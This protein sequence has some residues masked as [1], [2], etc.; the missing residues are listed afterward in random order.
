MSDPADPTHDPARAPTPTNRL[1]SETSLYLRQHMHDPV[2]WHPWG[3]EAR[4]RA[5]T[6]DKPLLVSIGYSACH[7]CH[8]ME[9]ESFEDPVTAALMNECFV[10]IKVD[11]EERPDVDQLYMDAV[12]RMQGHGGW[13]LT[14]F[15]RA[16][17]TPFYGGTYYPPEPRH[18]LPSFRDVLRSLHA[19]WRERRGE[20][21]EA[22]ARILEAL[23]ARPVGVAKELPGRALLGRAA[24]SLLHSADH[25]HGGFGGGPKFPTPT[26]LELLL[27]GCDLLSARPAGDALA[28]LVFTCRQM[29]GRGLYDP[30]GG[31]FHR[32]CVDGHWGVPHFEKMLYDQGQLLK[33]YADVWRRT[34][35]TEDDLVWPIRETADYLAAEMTAPEGGFFASQDADS[36]GVEGRFYVWTP[37]EVVAVLGA[38]SGAAFNDAYG[39]KPGGNFEGRTVLW[40]VA[41]GP[42]AALSEERRRLHAARAERV[43]PATDTKR[44]LSWNALAISGLAYAGSVLDAPGL[45]AQAEAAAGFVVRHLRRE[46]GGWWRIHAEG[47]AKVPAFLDDLSSWLAAC[48]DLHRAGAGPVWLERALDAADE[49]QA[50]FFDDDESDFFLTPMDG[51]RLA[52]RP[53]SD[54]DGATPDAGGLATLGLV[55]AAHLAGRDDFAR[56]AERVLRTHAFA[57]ERAPTGAPTMLRAAAW[58]ERPPAT[59]VIVGPPDDPATRALALRA[60]RL[61]APEEAVVAVAPGEGAGAVAASWLEGRT[62]I[63]GRPTAYVCQGTTCSLP[64]TDPADLA[65]PADGA[66]P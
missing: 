33:V 41:R 37:E 28:H 7:W 45:V 34:G 31:G 8:V 62:A 53:R 55:R 19:A 21:D 24:E 22:A 44:V 35:E 29:A 32:Y 2:D 4:A 11:R 60:R 18:G 52:H 49:I 56:T 47:R 66:R 48:L 13:P 1:A 17:G 54:H 3:E 61:L 12:V 50:R 39:V 51:E 20:V 58:A 36:E 40:D 38:E 43:A 14:L 30:L 10:C 57:L 42:H 26:N 6:E 64:T 65:R 15:C 27:A 9:H 25:G 5:K 46:G 23:A 59:A 63:R 16:D